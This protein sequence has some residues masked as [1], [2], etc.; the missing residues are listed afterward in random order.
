MTSRFVSLFGCLSLSATSF[1]FR[2]SKSSHCASVFKSQRG[3]ARAIGSMKR[4]AMDSHSSPGAKRQKEPEADYCDVETVRDGQ[5]NP[6]WPAS[7]EAMEK[8]RIFLREW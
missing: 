4:K 7:G 5:G 1:Q 2:S 6:I 8:A 3:K